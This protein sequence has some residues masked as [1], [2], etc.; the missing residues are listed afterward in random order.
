MKKWLLAATWFGTACFAW[1]QTQVAFWNF[2][3]TTN[4]ATTSTGELTPATGTG[5]FSMIGGATSTFAAG[6]SGDANTTDNSGANTTGYPASGS[7]KTA[8][9]QWNV[10]TVGHSNLLLSV[11]QRLSNT[12]ANTWVLQYT[13]DATGASTSGTAVWTDATTFTFT[14]APSGTGDTWY[15][16]TYNFTSITALNNNANAAF[17][18]VSDFDP[19]AGTYLAA[20]STSTYSGGGTSR[21]DL[22]TITTAPPV[23]TPAVVTIPAA[24][25]FIVVNE[26]V[27]THN[28]PFTISTPSISASK[29]AVE[30][31]VYTDA[32][33]D[34][35]FTWVNDTLDI[36]ANTSGV[37]NFP[38][39]I[40]DDNLSERAERIIVKIV[41]GDNVNVHATN[42]YQ[43][44]YIQDNDYVAPTASNELQ[45]ELLT[46]FSNGAAGTN[47][48][49]IVAYDSSNYRLYIAN[50]IGA[51]L[52]IVNLANPASP[53]LLNSI[54]I[55]TYGNINSVTV[56]NSLVVLAIENSNAQLNGKVVFLNQDGTFISQVEVGAMPDMITFNKD[57]TKVLT[58]NEGEPNADYSID[59]VGSVSIIDLT[60]GAA[61]LTQANVTTI[62]FEAFN[63][64][65]A[66]LLA[67]GIRIFSTSA[68]VAQ[69]LEPEYI[70]ISDDNMKA[71]V[72][73]QE[74]NA[75]MV[76]DLATAT[77][78]TI[79]A[80]GYSDYST[81]NGLDASDQ[82]GAVLIASAPVKGAYM[83]DALAFST[84]NG[85]G[86]VFSA[87][88]G[89][90]REFGSVVD[91]ARINSMNLDPV[92][93][94][95][96]HI[97][98]NNKL[99]GRLNALTYSGNTD[100]DNDIDEIHVMGGRSFSIWNASTGALVFDSKDLIEQ[101]TSNHPTFGTFFNASNTTG[102]ASLK[103]RSDDKGPEPE[104][105]ATAFIQGNHYLFV[106]LER[107]GGVM[108][109]NVND[110]Q[111]P[112]Y[113][114]YANNRTLAGS[115]P[116]LGAEG[117]IHIDA[118]ASPN[119]EELVIL[120]NEVS[121]TLSIYQVNSCLDLA[122]GIITTDDLTFCEGNSTLLSIEPIVGTTF[123]WIKDGQVLTSETNDT[124]EVTTAG[125][126]A[127]SISN[128]TLACSM[129]SPSIEI[130]VNPLPTVIASATDAS[131]CV[132]Q[133]TILT[134][135]G[136]SQY[137]WNNNA[138]N[139]V[140]ISPTTT[141]TYTVTG[142]DANGCT[143]TDDITVTVNPLP[144]VN[145]GSDITTCQN[146]TPVTLN[147]GSHTTYNWSTGATSQSIQV[148]STGTFS[149][150]VTNAAGCS[151][152][153]VIQV[154]VESCLGV[155]EIA[156]NFRI[157]P[158]PTSQVI[159]IE[160]EG[161]WM[162]NVI[163]YDLQ[164]RLW[165][166]E[167]VNGQTSQF[168]L[169]ELP[170]GM[171]QIEITSEQGVHHQSI[172]KL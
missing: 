62:G 45:M 103:N 165:K 134:A 130:T 52:D 161:I 128:S 8:G 48:A 46:S 113:A 159:N 147:A 24:S 51:K 73:M 72:S 151:A 143:N 77:I 124:L 98:K 28:V 70:T 148:A 84:I 86:Y 127:I 15:E 67:Q 13:T 115:G 145:L 31:S 99:F 35:D 26:N 91:A 139:G 132:G 88:E 54:D 172:T 44:V 41:G 21:F 150:S 42:N 71:Y 107:I 33:L 82:S 104:G 40:I 47:S 65:E 154:T 155:E 69:D 164:G 39:T 53:V 170:S 60:P 106:S 12:A 9:A 125:N 3:S 140:V 129:E 105:V 27:G 36:Q 100:G 59:P 25:N 153:D 93:F 16:R 112:V 19:T 49:E 10:S 169:S 55:T 117:I 38:L 11:W 133:E 76:I 87:N 122:G 135:T 64:Q 2:N 163:I 118:A 146:Q 109:F 66:I 4:D 80:L 158:N 83:P 78:D 110:P 90:S 34:A 167:I 37:V 101:I 166:N 61:A 149:V 68:S 137:T 95:D 126:Y 56:H 152:S 171:Y 30:L 123:E 57:F 114:G 14:P 120:A 142:T 22:F 131:L 144:T 74:N 157:Y 20:R 92:A 58:A 29:I 1:G 116:D 108:M 111:N 79:Y 119:G 7:P 23:S 121:S 141:T 43:I 160:S 94:P 6:Y 85:Q 136:A 32:T 81:G 168:D 75:L 5:S 17:R 63:S 50:S 18:I 162:Q 102:S 96:Q 138:Q 97:F 156:Q 89:D